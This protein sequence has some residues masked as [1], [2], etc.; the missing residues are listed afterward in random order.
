[1]TSVIWQQT[2][3]QSCV[4]CAFIPSRKCMYSCLCVNACIR[5]I[6]NGPIDKGM[7]RFRQ[8]FHMRLI[9]TYMYTYMYTHKSA[10]MGHLVDGSEAPSPA[11]RALLL[12]AT[13]TKYHVLRP[14]NADMRMKA[15]EDLSLSH[16]LVIAACVC[17][18]F[19][20][21]R[22]TRTHAHTRMYKPACIHMHFRT[23]V[24]S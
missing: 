5:A 3:A 10:H 11:A 18:K 12:S 22:S 17:G 20:L 13:E 15:P 19:S 8:A 16:M 9:H 2:H 24:L 4:K 21:S 1:M 23:H 6:L 7:N 14:P